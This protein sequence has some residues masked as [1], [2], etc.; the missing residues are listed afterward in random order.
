MRLDFDTFGCLYLFV[1]PFVVQPFLSCWLTPNVNDDN[2]N[3]YVDERFET[4]LEAFR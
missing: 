1:I 2:V 4:V 3:G